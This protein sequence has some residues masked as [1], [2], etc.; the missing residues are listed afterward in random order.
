MITIQ[1]EMIAIQFFVFT[2]SDGPCFV[3]YGAQ[4]KG[5]STFRNGF[6]FLFMI[7]LLLFYLFII[8]FHIL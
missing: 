8:Y 5:I 4:A 6:I 1:Y 2:L 7:Y 3:A